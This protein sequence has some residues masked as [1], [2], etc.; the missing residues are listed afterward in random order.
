MVG[1]VTGLLHI[2]RVAAPVDL[3]N[4]E[5]RIG[6]APGG[7]GVRHVMVHGLDRL[8]AFLRQAYVPTPAIERTWRAPATCRVHSIPHVGL[9]AADLEALGL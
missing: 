8:T 3:V 2:V 4:T 6:F 1:E 9:T 7:F 5:Y